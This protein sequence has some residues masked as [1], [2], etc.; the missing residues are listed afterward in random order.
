[1]LTTHQ[2]DSAAEDENGAIISH[3]QVTHSSVEEWDEEQLIPSPPPLPPTMEATS[4][5][6]KRQKTAMRLRTVRKWLQKIIYAQAVANIIRAL[7]IFIL[8]K[9]MLMLLIF[10]Q[11][12]YTS[13]FHVFKFEYFKIILFYN[14]PYLYSFFLIVR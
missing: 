11:V 7:P 2:N 12:L 6:K 13:S 4:R 10:F 14:S 8:E 9:Y 1:M 5:M 3:P